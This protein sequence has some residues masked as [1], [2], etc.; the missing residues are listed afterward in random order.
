MKSLLQGLQSSVETNFQ[1]IKTKLCDLEDR[2]VKVEEKQIELQ[3]S[4]SSSE[5]NSSCSP[6]DTRQRR[7]PPDLQVFLLHFRFMACTVINP[8]AC[9]AWCGVLLDLVV[10][11]VSCYSR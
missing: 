7:S 4:P 1:Q 2:V 11:C 5:Y 6:N 10:L 9:V 8:Q 3:N